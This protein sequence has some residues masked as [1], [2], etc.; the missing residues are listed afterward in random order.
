MKVLIPSINKKKEELKLPQDQRA[1]VIFDQCKG[2]ITEKFLGLLEQNNMS[3]VTS[4][5]AYGC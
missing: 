1:L 3:V 5:A 2:E 4:L